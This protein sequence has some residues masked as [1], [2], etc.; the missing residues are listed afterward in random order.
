MCLVN[1]FCISKNEHEREVPS[2]D[3]KSGGTLFPDTWKRVPYR[4]DVD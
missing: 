4:N 2:D 3:F 1:G